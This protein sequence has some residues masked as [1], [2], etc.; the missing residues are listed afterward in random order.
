MFSSSHTSP[1]YL[2]VSG[3]D[4]NPASQSEKAQDSYSLPCWRHDAG[5]TARNIIVAC[6]SGNS[7]KHVPAPLITPFAAPTDIKNSAALDD[8]TYAERLFTVNQYL[9]RRIRKLELTNQIIRE[10]YTEVQEILEAERQSKTTQMGALE[11]KHD[12]ELND[13][14]TELTE[15]KEGHRDSFNINLKS[16]NDSGSDSDSDYGFRPGFSTVMTNEPKS[17]SAA[18]GGDDDDVEFIRSSNSSPTSHSRNGALSPAK[19][20]RGVSDSTDLALV[21]R[22]T[23][24]NN[25]NTMPAELEIEFLEP[26]RADGDHESESDETEDEGHNSVCSESDSDSDDGSGTDED[27]A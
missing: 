3:H 16:L 12:E 22:G 9:L 5:D 4:G 26:G 25:K 8:A 10:A 1:G 14:Y 21:Q 18:G 20:Q 2:N 13:L 19:A 7:E 17:M 11:K 27:D 15:R 23:K 24:V 6:N